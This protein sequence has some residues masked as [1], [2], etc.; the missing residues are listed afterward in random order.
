MFYSISL[1][2]QL[3]LGLILYFF[4]S[5]IT[6]IVFSDL[7]SALANSGSRFFALEHVLIMVLAVILAHVG[8][9]MARRTED[10]VLKHRQAAIWFSLSLIALLLGMPW[11]R[12]LLPGFS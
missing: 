11:F 7:S 2:I 1:D 10:A 8:V 6:K 9:A 12:P 5:P 4:L 3:L